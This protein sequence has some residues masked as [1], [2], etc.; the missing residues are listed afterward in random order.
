MNAMFHALLK[1]HAPEL[2]P[3]QAGGRYDHPIDR[4]RYDHRQGDWDR[5]GDRYHGSMERGMRRGR[6]PHSGTPYESDGYG[7]GRMYPRGRDRM[8]R[9]GREC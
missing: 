7:G 2:L 1:A 6:E 9:C 5:S 8:E 4:Y 3:A